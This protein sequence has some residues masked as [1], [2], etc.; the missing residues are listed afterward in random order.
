MGS[1]LNRTF[2]LLVLVGILSG[3][4][5]D[6]ALDGY[7]RM[8]DMLF[9]PNVTT[10]V[11][12]FP[13][14]IETLDQQIAFIFRPRHDFFYTDKELEYVRSIHSMDKEGF[15]DRLMTLAEE[16][17]S[18][19]RSS[20]EDRDKFFASKC[21]VSLP[22]YEAEKHLPRLKELF[23]DASLPA[24]F[25]ERILSS[26]LVISAG[27]D[28]FFSMADRI[29]SNSF[30]NVDF[31]DAIRRMVLKS[32]RDLA[33]RG[34]WSSEKKEILGKTQVFLKTHLKTSSHRE[35]WDWM[36]RMLCQ[37]DPAYAESAFRREQRERIDWVS[38]PVESPPAGSP[39]SS[40]TKPE[41]PRYEDSTLRFMDEM[42]SDH[43]ESSRI[44]REL[45]MK[46][47]TEKLSSGETTADYRRNAAEILRK[48]LADEPDESFRKEMVELAKRL[49]D[50]DIT[51][52]E[53]E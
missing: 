27:T 35:D 31:S 17:L 39:P 28:D 33:S 42:M 25:R 7:L 26:Y 4:S 8:E 10:V 45:A 46:Y 24:P 52:L 12:H 41:P 9:G 16:K 32:M 18:S 11:V 51:Q 37:V 19:W 21:I 23:E 1:P 47:V 34:I 29:M 13:D 48:N 53:E 43:G 44:A 3:V 22:P 5:A 14:D 50:E 20:W 6:E 40:P 2:L 38:P 49:E 15:G 30:D 36:D